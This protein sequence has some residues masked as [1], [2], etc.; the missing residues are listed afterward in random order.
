MS[1]L[2]IYP[3]AVESERPV[4][5][6]VSKDHADIS[7]QLARIGVRFERWRADRALAADAGEEEV[8]SA[9]AEAI[10]GLNETYGFQ[11]IDVVALRP[12]N[13]KRDEFRA[14]FLAEHTHADFEV[15]FF[16]DGS[17]LFYLHV[18]DKVYC[19]LCEKGDL[20]S[21][22][23]NTTHWFDM[24]PRPDFK[25]IRLFVIPDGWIGEFTGSDIAGQFPSFDQFVAEYA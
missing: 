19:V 13:P 5:L 20:I 12:D 4:A 8:K 24:G 7:A 1:V 25:C 2:A 17:G 18:G 9:Y 15:R 10:A 23:A 6:D 16:V 11:S 22:P 3:D 14:K 21:V